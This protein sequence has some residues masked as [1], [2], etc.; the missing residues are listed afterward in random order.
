MAISIPDRVVV[1]D[2]GE[3]I[4]R[5]P[6]DAERQAL[7]AVAG[8]DPEAFWAAYDRHRD[9]LDQGVIK[10]AEYWAVIAAE[11]GRSWPPSV[12]QRLWTL[13]FR[14]W[15][16]VEPGV[17]EL[18]DELK[19]G[20]TRLALLSNAGYDFGDPFRHS[21]LGGYFERVFVSAEL[22]LIK[23]DP[24]I[25]RIVIE[26]LGIDAGRMVFVDNKLPNVD[27]AVGLGATG[28]HFV[29]VAELRGFLERLA[30]S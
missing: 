20:G 23:P 22:G 15:F 14:S 26:E 28:H 27:G 29:G 18:L 1:F 11:T 21:P 24:E 25:Y 12:V 7:L 30:R 10:P 4:S 19:D 9:D 3:V 5:S 8:A 2:Y 16:S 17:I 13:D 6:T